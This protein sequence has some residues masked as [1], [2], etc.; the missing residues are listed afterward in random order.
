MNK[1]IL[2]EPEKC[3]GCRTCA[4]ACSFQHEEEFRPSLSRIGTL[5]LSDIGRFATV[6]CQQCEQ[7][8]CAEACP[9]NAI[10]VDKKTSSVL[11]DEALCVGCRSCFI[12]CPFGVP[13]IHY[14]KGTMIKCDLCL[15]D[16]QC[17]QECPR[18]ALSVVEADEASQNKLRKAA[19]RLMQL[20][21]KCDQ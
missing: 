5:W 10:R 14:T 7:P 15:G 18:K 1:F 16:P 3:I 19:N 17:V 2:F 20:V 8:M 21:E 11:V 9:M 6:T 4:L 13:S 12:A